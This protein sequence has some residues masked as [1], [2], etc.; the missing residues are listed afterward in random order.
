M[1][2]E[3]LSLEDE[4][5][6]SLELNQ[7]YTSCGWIKLYAFKFKIKRHMS[8]EVGMLPIP[9]LKWNPK[10]WDLTNHYEVYVKVSRLWEGWEEGG[11]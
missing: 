7:I 2:S 10:H 8:C 9:S 11:P 4:A 3:K 1:S 5:Q 6:D